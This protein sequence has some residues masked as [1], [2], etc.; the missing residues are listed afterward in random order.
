MLI[1]P[2]I[3]QVELVEHGG[4]QQGSVDAGPR[5]E[6]SGGER[7]EAG[8]RFTHLMVSNAANDCVCTNE[9]INKDSES[10]EILC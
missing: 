10:D 6:D 3:F 4:G 1:I 5:G 2:L 9:M 8:T 7:G